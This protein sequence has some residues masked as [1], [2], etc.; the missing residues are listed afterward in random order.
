MQWFFVPDQLHGNGNGNG[1]G[2]WE[3]TAGEMKMATADVKFTCT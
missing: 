2:K 3:M 1:N